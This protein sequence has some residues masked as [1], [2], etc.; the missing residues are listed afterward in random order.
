MPSFLVASRG[1]SQNVPS[2][3]KQALEQEEGCVMRTDQEVMERVQRSESLL[4]EDV[5][6]TQSRQRI[7]GWVTALRW[8]LG[9]SDEDLIGYAAQLDAKKR[10]KE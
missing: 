3:Q 7:I 8:V 6:S 2:V 4:E 10:D 5:L 1:K 9:S